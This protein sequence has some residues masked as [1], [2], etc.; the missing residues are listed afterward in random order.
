MGHEYKLHDHKSCILFTLNNSEVQR[1][2]KSE[3][4]YNLL[5]TDALTS[6]QEFLL[7]LAQL[8]KVPTVNINMGPLSDIFNYVHGNEPQLQPYLDP[9][10]FIQHAYFPKKLLNSL[11]SWLS[12]ACSFYYKPSLS[13][14]YND[15]NARL[16]D[17]INI[18]KQSKLLHSRTPYYAPTLLELA[19][20]VS[21][22]VAN[23][24]PV[25]AYTNGQTLPPNIVPIPSIHMTDVL[26]TLNPV[27]VF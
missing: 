20:N 11:S 21:L 25:I 10:N 9:N 26:P 3:E 15:Y 23:F 27:C 2:V 18:I 22:T 12:N 5:I 24:H 13:D 7:V 19:A 17:D 14:V 16:K 6:K 1:I 8:L 4:K